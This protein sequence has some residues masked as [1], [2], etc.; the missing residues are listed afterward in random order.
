V[1]RGAE[2][3]MAMA[4][5]TDAA[6]AAGRV[7]ARFIDQH[8]VARPALGDRAGDA[9]GGVGLY[10]GNRAGC[11]P[12]KHLGERCVA[13]CCLGI[14]KLSGRSNGYFAGDVCPPGMLWV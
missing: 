13:A 5:P 7:L 2:A 10:L 11:M 1:G 4:R 3:V 8:A 14:N 6:R 9:T 12:R